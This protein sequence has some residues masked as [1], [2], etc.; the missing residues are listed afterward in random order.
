MSETSTEMSAFDDEIEL[1]PAR[2][3]L[4]GIVVAPVIVVDPAVVVGNAIAIQVGTVNS[5]VNAWLSQILG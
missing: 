4:F 1:L 3:T 2:Q 5:M